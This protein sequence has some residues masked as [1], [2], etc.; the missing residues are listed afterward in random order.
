MPLNPELARLLPVLETEEVV[1]YGEVGIA[2]ARAAHDRSVA[3]LTPTGCRAQVGSV[4]DLLVPGPAGPVAIR[5][6]RPQ[7]AQT[8][9]ILLWFHGGGWCTGSLDTGD[10]LAR[11]LC[12]GLPATVVSIDYRLAPEHPWPAAIEDGLAVLRWAVEHAHQLSRDGA[13]IAI[14]GDSAGGNIAAVVAHLATDEGQALGA[15]LLVYPALDLDVERSDRYPSLRTFAHGYALPPENLVLAVGQYLPTGADPADP[16]ISPVRRRA[17]AGLPP[18][19]LTVAECDPV[20]DHGRV[21]AEALRAASV[22]VVFR[23]GEGLI[24][25]SFDLIGSA[26]SVRVELDIMMASLRALLA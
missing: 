16:R 7:L 11:E 9:P 25:G 1:R 19:V 20:R 24:H 14:G 6:Y 18:T 3:R 13:Q 21:Y 8:P 5:V 15:Q 2:S 26:P 22:P 4:E 10:V 12:S 23:E 17:L